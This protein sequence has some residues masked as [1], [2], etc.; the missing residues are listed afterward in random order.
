[1]FLQL[2]SEGESS[3]VLTLPIQYRLSKSQTVRRCCELL[4]AV[5]RRQTT[6]THTCM[7]GR[8]ADEGSAVSLLQ[9]P[10]ENVEKGLRSALLQRCKAGVQQAIMAVSIK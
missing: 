6:R 4:V 3:G 10:S 9:S 7:H 2:I 8:M 1:M 5:G